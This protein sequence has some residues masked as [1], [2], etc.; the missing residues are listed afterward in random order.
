MLTLRIKLLNGLD[1]LLALALGGLLLGTLLAFGG[2]V[3][4]ARPAIAGLTLAI[5]GSMLPMLREV[6]SYQDAGQVMQRVMELALV[7]IPDLDHGSVF[8]LLAADQAV[9]WSIVL[10]ALA[11][12]A[13]YLVIALASGLILLRRREL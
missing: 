8:A 4:W 2:G 5:A 1:R 10:G 12:L 13:G 6:A 9:P 3:W 7:V 11:G